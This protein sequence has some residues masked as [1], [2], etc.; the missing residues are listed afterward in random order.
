MVAQ[1][2]GYYN[3]PFKNFRV[4]TQG[5]PLSPTIFYVVVDMVLR[6][7]FTLMAASEKAVLPVSG[8]HRG[9]W[10]VHAA[11]GGIV[12]CRQRD[13]RA[14]AEDLPTVGL[15]YTDRAL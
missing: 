10:E 3:D 15:L 5:D 12:L 6:H 4:V 9:I 2:G 14:D 13:S 7:W 11:S 8:Y 1:S